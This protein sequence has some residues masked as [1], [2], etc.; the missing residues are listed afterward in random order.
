MI[1]RKKRFLETEDD[2]PSAGLVNL[3]DVMLVLAVGFLIFGVLSL[4]DE[5]LISDSQ[6]ASE[7]SVSVKTGEMIN[8]T[9]SNTTGAGDG[10]QEMGTVYKDPQT[11]KLIL[12]K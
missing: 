7:N 4:G 2:D 10:F 5:N 9:T 6:G 1:K 11:G 3:T 12:V 8:N